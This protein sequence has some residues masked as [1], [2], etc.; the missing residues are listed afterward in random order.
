MR[1]DGGNRLGLV[2]DK[3]VEAGYA[4]FEETASLE[5]SMLG[6]DF[7]GLRGIILQ[8]FKQYAGNGCPANI[9]HL[10]DL[11]EAGDGH[12]AGN[13]RDFDPCFTRIS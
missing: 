5:E 3:K 12:E 1:K 13:D 11:V 4:G 6:A 9:G 7:Y 2:H 8:F 10:S